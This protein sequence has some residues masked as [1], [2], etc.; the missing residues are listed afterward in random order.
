MAG[1]ALCFFGG[2][3]DAARR[4]CHV[5][6]QRG[7]LLC[8]GRRA[9]GEALE[10]FVPSSEYLRLPAQDT[11]HWSLHTPRKLTSSCCLAWETKRPS[12]RYGMGNRN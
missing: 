5:L 12:K 1:E 6:I 11:G 4:D 8:R 9:L 3:E 7:G 10:G 2:G